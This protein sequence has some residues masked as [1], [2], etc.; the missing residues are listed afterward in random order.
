MSESNEVH[1]PT[2]NPTTKTERHRIIINATHLI[3]LYE[4]PVDS[5]ISEEV[6]AKESL[7]TEIPLLG[8]SIIE[9]FIRMKIQDGVASPDQIS[10]AFADENI[11]EQVAQYLDQVRDYSRSLNW[12]NIFTPDDV[13]Q[14]QTNVCQEMALLGISSE[15][16]SKIANMD[17]V[18]TDSPGV[19]FPTNE[20]VSVSQLQIVRNALDY[21]RVYGDSIP[22][23]QIISAYIKSTMSHELGHK[24]DYALDNISST[25]PFDKT[26]GENNYEKPSER[27]A[28]YWGRLG[29]IEDQKI[30]Q[31]ISVMHLAKVNQLWNS[32]NSYNQTHENK[33]DLSGIFRSIGSKIEKSSNTMSLFDARLHLYSGNVAENYALPYSRE[34]I[35]SAIKTKSTTN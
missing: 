17:I 11:P 5:K 6:I 18:V 12:E 26:W 9:D 28:E 30:A 25:I 35:I 15:K 20:G 23:E 33:V 31:K 34:T 21:I 3:P 2:G 32:I 22:I 7:P 14:V 13:K 27:F 4:R 1:K 16:I 10:E 24:I 8:S 29:S 19:S